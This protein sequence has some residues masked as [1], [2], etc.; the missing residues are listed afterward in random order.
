MTSLKKLIFFCSGNSC[1]CSNSDLKAV[2]VD[3]ATK[4]N[5]NCAGNPLQKCGSEYGVTLFGLSGNIQYT[6][7]KR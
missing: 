5:K 6:N 4:C 7:E 3:A 1:F 2:S